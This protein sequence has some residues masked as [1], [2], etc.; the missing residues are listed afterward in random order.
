MIAILKLCSYYIVAIIEAIVYILFN[1]I[2]EFG[3]LQFFFRVFEIV[4]DDTKF[5]LYTH[6]RVFRDLAIPCIIIISFVS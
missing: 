4:D 1:F 6:I 2:F 3:D 5:L